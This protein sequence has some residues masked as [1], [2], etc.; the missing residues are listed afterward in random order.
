[1][2]DL[3][4]GDEVKRK[5]EKEGVRGWWGKK[6]REKNNNNNKEYMGG[7]KKKEGKKKKNRGRG[8]TMGRERERKKMRKISILGV[9][10][11]INK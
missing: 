2:R 1:M 8:Y 11:K 5:K 10:K 4:E 3:R 7:G 6:R 9:V